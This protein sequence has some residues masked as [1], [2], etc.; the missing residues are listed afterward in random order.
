[1]IVNDAL[2]I[3]EQL[4]KDM[5]QLVDT[6]QCEWKAVVENPELRKQF[7]HFAD[8]KDADD[9]LVFIRE[10]EQKRPADWPD[11][12]P[13]QLSKDMPQP[14]QWQ[15]VQM[16][17]VDAVPAN[18]GIAVRYGE[19]Q[20][21]IYHF[22]RRNQW[23]ATQNTCP[24]RKDN[25]LARGILGSHGDEPKVACPLHKKTFSLLSG[26]GLN[27][28]EYRIRTFSVQIK[29]DQIWVRLPPAQLLAQELAC[30]KAHVCEQEAV[31][32]AASA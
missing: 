7:R 15:W 8:S 21:A 6:Y 24:H 32:L 23:Y 11:T 28:P 30:S 31:Q 4:E 13:I 12:A 1:V 18:G 16:S 3:C 29:D 27:D 19:T 22:A 17:G 26:E 10:R 2:G 5:Q 20:I 25:V 9:K 14:D